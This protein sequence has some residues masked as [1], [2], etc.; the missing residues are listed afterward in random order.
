MITSVAL[1]FQVIVEA[2]NVFDIEA[3]HGFSKVCHDRW[4]EE[5]DD[6]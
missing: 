3:A 6:D 2:R 1:L 5:K 4:I